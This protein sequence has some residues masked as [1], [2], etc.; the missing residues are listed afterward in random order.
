[1]RT[2]LVLRLM[3]LLIIAII[4]VVA[5]SYAVARNLLIREYQSQVDAVVVNAKHALELIDS[6]YDMLDRHIE[7]HMAEGIRQFKRLYEASPKPVNLEA[8]KVQLGSEYDLMIIDRETTIIDSTMLEAL[9]FNFMQFDKELGEKINVIRQSDSVVHERL[10]T[11]V[12]T[13]L[14]TKFTYLSA[15]NHEVLLEIAYVE[16]IFTSVLESL[17]PVTRMNTIRDAHSIVDSI[18]IY[19]VYGYEYSHG[20]DAYEPTTTSLE[21]V[22]RA[23]DEK[24]Y[25]EAIG[26]RTKRVYYIPDSMPRLL[27]DH[28]RVLVITFN[29]EYLRYLQKSLSIVILFGSLLAL[30]AFSAILYLEINTMTKPLNR[31][32]Q[33]AKEVTSGNYTVEIPICGTEET[34]YLTAVFNEMI[35]VVNEH[36]SDLS[37]QFKVTLYSMVDGVVVVDA[38]GG[39][40]LMN[41]SAEGLLGVSEN[42]SVG[43]PYKE[44]LGFSE[45][46]DPTLEGSLRQDEYVFERKEH[47][48]I[49]LAYTRA[50]LPDGGQVF[51]LRDM[52]EHL[53]KMKRIQ[54]LSQ[55]DQLTGLLNRSAYEVKVVET[56]DTKNLPQTLIMVDLNGLKLVNDA[57]GHLLGDALLKRAASLLKEMF[58]GYGDIYR[59]G[60]DEFV[61]LLSS[62]SFEEGKKKVELLQNRAKAIEVPPVVLSLSAGIATR[63]DE[64][65]S[66]HELFI[67]AES[68]MYQQKLTESIHVHKF[69]IDQVASLYFERVPSA[70]EH[71]NRVMEQ[72][73]HL[74]KLM[75]LSWQSLDS[76]MK[77]AWYHD[78]GKV[79]SSLD[80][81]GGFA[82]DDRHVQVGYQILRSVNAYAMS[83]EIVL[84]HHECWDG[85]G[86]PRGLHGKDIQV[87]A[88]ILALCDFCDHLLYTLCLEREGVLERVI[89][90]VGKAFSPELV[91]SWKNQFLGEQSL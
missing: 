63:E 33:A 31:L 80:V 20:G 72:A 8:L 6:G 12:G 87:E 16:D 35:R 90:Q 36:Y 53:E 11:N 43:R 29:T 23:L 86:F 30:I 24:S 83:A 60:G 1:M 22:K 46:L 27:S 13:G 28:G 41:A 34:A 91:E 54:Y 78:I 69:L 64:F 44:V 77:A 39:V 26:N 84:S 7:V 58:E 40:L 15:D 89:A 68:A 70:K 51:V 9:N 38:S 62:T 52:T 48:F 49:T 21:I 75:G 71:A 5:F 2:Q 25:V 74:G 50:T 81:S 18:K 42:E 10:R 56:L 85:T 67:R 55:N 47:G 82:Q 66:L 79:N 19:D 45:A 57:F 14:I 37:K 32:T 76:L 59:L 88:Q 17:D 4:I 61:V 73:N 3:P 65:V